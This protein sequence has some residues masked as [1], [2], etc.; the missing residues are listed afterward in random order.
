MAT[1]TKPPSL[2]VLNTLAQNRR[3]VAYG[4]FGLGAAAGVVALVLLYQTGAEWLP[5][6][7][8]LTLFGLVAVISGA[9]FLA[10]EPSPGQE[11]DNSR[12][13]VLAVGGAFGFFLTF[14]VLWQAWRWSSYFSGGLE[15]WRGPEGWRIWLLI[16]GLLAGLAIMFASLLLARSEE[17]NNALLRRLLYGY[18]AVLTGIL[19]LLIL[20]LVNVLA[21]LYVPAQSDWTG[22][23]IY[24][25]NPRSINILQG[26]KEPVTVTVITE[27]RGRTSVELDNLLQNC[28]AVTDKIQVR[29]LSR[30]LDLDTLDKLVKKYKLVDDIGMLVEYGT[31]PNVEHQ[32][33]RM[34]EIFV[35]SQPS[36]PS[37]EEESRSPFKF[38]G[39]DALMSA[40][41]FLQE[42]KKKPVVY[43]TQGN[44]ELSIDPA[45]KESDRYRATA[46]RDRLQKSNYE[47]KGLK[48]VPVASE[49]S[50]DAQVVTST[51]VPDDASVVMILGPRTPF[52]GQALA[53]LREYANPTDSSKPKGKLVV[54]LDIVTEG[55]PPVSVRTGL[56]A[57][58]AGFNVEVG[59]DRILRLDERNPERVLVVANPELR[60]TNPVATALEGVGFNWSRVRTVQPKMEGNPMQPGSTFRAEPL[61][62]A[63]AQPNQI[64]AETDFGLNA[65]A[66]AK[67]ILSNPRKAE[68]QEKIAQIF[69]NQVLSVAVA[70]SET[71]PVDPMNPHAR[72]SSKGS[73]KPRMVVIG[74]AV[75]ASD[76]YLGGPLGANSASFDLLTSCL[77]WLRE[78]PNS[79]GLD[80]KDR[81]RYRLEPTTNISRLLFLPSGLMLLGIVGFGVGVWVIRRR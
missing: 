30:D 39:E 78:K 31:E 24:T 59:N 74:N 68:N 5:E 45:S 73:P 17:Q 61:L 12:M 1:A 2:N 8:G 27:T 26:L 10:F 4:L 42:G 9:L 62:V 79:I 57:L 49:K 22:S 72:L 40:I 34:Q 50:S 16:L 69:S 25:L 48:L 21:Y 58:L 29:R 14:T 64:W 18:N 81:D 7:L 41:T 52:S 70:V 33:I 15:A 46:L 71:P 53:A 23:Q 6:I 76:Q 35:Q 38:N 65:A 77:A 66:L 51:K 60:E 56:E 36:Q 11:E 3:P 19:L 44:G 37:F 28:Q 80:P 67:D 32:F 63:I 47:V 55:Q 54:M 20:L 75:F 43:F 13:L